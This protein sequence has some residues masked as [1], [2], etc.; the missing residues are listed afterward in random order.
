[1]CAWVTFDCA[2]VGRI[3]PQTPSARSK[4][5]RIE[6]FIRP[7]ISK[8][9]LPLTRS[10]IC[11]SR[12]MAEL[13]AGFFCWFF[14]GRLGLSLRRGFRRLLGGGRFLGTV[15]FLRWRLL[16]GSLFIRIASVI[17]GVEPRSLEDQTRAGAQQAFH[18]AVAPLRQPAKLL[19]AFKERFVAH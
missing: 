14:L 8:P 16:F 19:R 6:N 4:K 11:L 3:V 10:A 13:F 12:I 2:L 5:M 18:F 17:G 1:M 15:G 7:A 9:T